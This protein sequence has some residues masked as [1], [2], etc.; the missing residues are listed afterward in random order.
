MMLIRYRART[1]VAGGSD[2]NSGALAPAP[3]S[4]IVAVLRASPIF[5]LIPV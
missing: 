1:V 4:P 2:R 5:V 3:S